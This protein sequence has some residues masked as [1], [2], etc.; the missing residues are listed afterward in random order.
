MRFPGEKKIFEE[1]HPSVSVPFFAEIRI[2][3]RKCLGRI[4]N[5]FCF[6]TGALYHLESLTNQIT[7]NKSL[8]KGTSDAPFFLFV[9]PYLGR[10]EDDNVPDQVQFLYEGSGVIITSLPSTSPPMAFG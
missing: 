7:L 6:P 3:Y 4:F 2:N 9:I 8:K 5:Q 1:V 10:Y